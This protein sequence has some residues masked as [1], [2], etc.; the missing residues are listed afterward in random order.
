MSELPLVRAQNVM[1]QSPTLRRLGVTKKLGCGHE[2][3]VYATDHGTVVKVSLNRRLTLWGQPL[4]EAELAA[5]QRLMQLRGEHSIVPDIYGAGR[6][7]GSFFS[8]G[9]Y[10]EREP[11]NDLQ[12]SEEAE[13]QFLQ[14]DLGKL[15]GGATT[16]PVVRLPRSIVGL[17]RKQLLDIARGF[18]WLQKQGLDPE[19]HN[20][21]ENWGVRA[22]GSVALRDL[23]H[24]FVRG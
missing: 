19:D 4:P 21:P 9:I 13:L 20:E 24:I 7:E 6:L 18:V 14:D 8:H 16:S 15:L 12:L 2:G 17:E 3:C 5:A 1:L 23:G 22:D 11:L 10:I